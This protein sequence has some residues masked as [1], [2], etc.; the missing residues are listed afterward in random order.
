[1]NGNRMLCDTPPMGWN[2]FDCFGGKVTEADVKA[3]ADYM[4]EHLKS[5]G[6]EYIVVD[7]AWYADCDIP[8][9]LHMD[10]YGRL[11]PAPRMFPS[12]A[13]GKGFEPLADYIHDKGLKFGI[14]IMRGIPKIAIEKNAPILASKARAA[15]IA[16]K[17]SLCGWWEH[18]YGVDPAK[19][20]AQA[21]YDSLVELYAGWGVDFIKADDIS[22]PYSA[23]EI[24]LLNNA[25]TKCGRNIVLSLSPGP[26]RL[27]DA[28]HVTTHANMWRLSGDLWDNW[29]QLLASF[30]FCEEWNAHRSPG[31]WP[32]LD[33]LPLGRLEVVAARESSEERWSRLTRDEQITMITLWVIFRSP[34]MIGGHLPANDDWTLSL[35][36]NDEVLDVLKRSDSNRQLYLTE[37]KAAWAASGPDGSTYLAL[38]NL[39]DHLATVEAA[40]E[41]VG[42][43]G[44]CKARDLWLHKDLGPKDSTV[45]FELPPHGAKLLRL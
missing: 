41:P 26:T 42:L 10:E 37:D 9:P 33:M 40:F 2:S 5:H 39:K 32:D 35:F 43:I 29:Q 18:M 14:H 30:K 28:P 7:I 6:W 1:M 24:E 27:E 22:K 3:N 4:A 17:E 36:T 38:F 12:S 13:G 45:S 20:G 11:I 15:D 31:H 25:I 19:N 16:N 21:Y 23:G 44:T 34:L 8:N